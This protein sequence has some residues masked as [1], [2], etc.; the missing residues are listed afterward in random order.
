MRPFLSGLLAEK[1]Q[2]MNK[3]SHYPVTRPDIEISRPGKNLRDTRE[4][5][6]PGIAKPNLQAIPELMVPVKLAIINYSINE[7]SLKIRKLTTHSPTSK[8][9]LVPGNSR[10]ILYLNTNGFISKFLPFRPKE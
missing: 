5:W 4:V 7:T 9:A 2:Q 8:I 1:G 10:F 6:K 3:K